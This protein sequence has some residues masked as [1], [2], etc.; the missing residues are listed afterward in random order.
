MQ[1]RRNGQRHLAG[2]ILSVVAVLM[3]LLSF[4]LV[5]NSVLQGHT[6]SPLV[7]QGHSPIVLFAKGPNDRGIGCVGVPC[8][9][10]NS[11]NYV[12]NLTEAYGPSHY[13]FTTNTIT[14]GEALAGTWTL[15]YFGTGGHQSAGF[16]LTGASCPETN[17]DDKNPNH[18]HY[19]PGCSNL[20]GKLFDPDDKPVTVTL[21]TGTVTGGEVGSVSFTLNLDGTLTV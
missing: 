2:A 9:G 16:T 5:A 13:N 7:L 3:L 15:Y 10:V 11:I 12:N 21:L 14:V 19:E 20:T 17:G 6:P 8:G 1:E 4:N 18:G